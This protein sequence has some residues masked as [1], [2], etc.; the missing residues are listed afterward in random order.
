MASHGGS[1]TLLAAPAHVVLPAIRREGPRY[2]KI[3]D[4]RN[5]R[6][7]TAV[8]ILSPANKSKGEDRELYLVKRNE[9]LATGVNLVEIDL[10]RSW[11]RMPLDNPPPAP[12]DYL[13]LVSRASEFPQAGV[14]P[15]SVRDP[16]PT[17]P[18]PLASPDPDVLLP[19]KPCFDR[20]FAEGRYESDINY[21]EP[22]TPP[23][24]EPDATWARDLL[25]GWSNGQR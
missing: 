10:L 15:L 12:S 21:A 4:R 18:I 23:L 5:R 16:L 3:I 9:Y 22:P 14:W 2:L 1:A 8:E 6:V 13:I 7:V 19:L 17:L 20:A 25:A 11:E 24:A